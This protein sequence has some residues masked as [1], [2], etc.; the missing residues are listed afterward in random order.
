MTKK[1]LE[2]RHGTPEEFAEAVWAAC[3]HLM[4]TPMEAK[5]SVSEYWKEWEA[6][7]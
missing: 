2:D 7:E 5:E 6:A 1:E 4:V 3:E